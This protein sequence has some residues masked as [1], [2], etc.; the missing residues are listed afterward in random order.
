MTQKSIDNDPGYLEIVDKL[1]TLEPGL[2]GLIPP[3]RFEQE[4]KKGG[5]AVPA[6][7]EGLSDSNPEVRLDAAEALGQLKD[8]GQKALGA[9]KKVVENDPDGTVKQAAAISLIQ[10][11]GDALLAEVTKN[12]QDENPEVAA[13][14]AVT[15]GKVGD[16][17]VVPNLLQ[18]FQTTDQLVGSAIA[19]AL[20]RLKDARALSWLAAALENGFVPANAAEAIGRIGD[21]EAVPV[22]AN[23]LRSDN[24]DTRAYAARAMGMMKEPKNLSGVRAHTWFQRKEEMIG[25]LQQTLQEDP[26]NKVRI[27]AAIALFELGDKKAGKT[28]LSILRSL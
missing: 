23:C 19:W 15:L 10:I 11:G 28:F 14:A 1:E 3:N 21:P 9:L 12:L 16:P 2:T 13:H 8:K 22:L 27:F 4:L 26:V 20:G 18:A 17:R 25:A 6:L 5:G 7:I 24:E